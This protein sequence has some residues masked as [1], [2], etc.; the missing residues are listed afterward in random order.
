MSLIPHQQ[1]LGCYILMST[2]LQARVDFRVGCYEIWLPCPVNHQQLSLMP[3]CGRVTH[4][5]FGN[6]Q[7]QF[8]SP[9]QALHP[10]TSICNDHSS[11]PLPKYLSQSQESGF[12][13]SLSRISITASLAVVSRGY[14]LTCWPNYTRNS[15][16]RSKQ[17]EHY[18]NGFV[19]RKGSDK[20]VS[21]LRTCST[22]Q[23]RW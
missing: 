1:N 5:R 12:L 17:Q 3:H 4:H 20:V 18:Q 13:P 23:R 19:L 7:R 16:L 21:S 9:R 6:L 14:R 2:N 8:R 11:Q 15:S 22:S 10:P